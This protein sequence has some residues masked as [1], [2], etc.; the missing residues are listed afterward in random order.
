[1]KKLLVCLLSLTILI[2]L[3][4]CG[5]N[6][7][8]DS[9]TTTQAT[10]AK[11]AKEFELS[12]FDFVKGITAGWNLGNTLESHYEWGN[13]PKK[14]PT[15][16][17]VETGWNNPKTTKEMIDKVKSSGF[18][19]I[20][21]PVSWYIFTEEKNGNFTINQAWLNRVQEVVDYVVENDMYCIVN[22]H[23]DDRDW[24]Q[25][26]DNKDKFEKIK[27]RYKQVWKI[28]GT[29]FKD[30]GEKLVLEAANELLYKTQSGYDWW[31]QDVEYFA[32]QNELYKI[33]VDTVRA[34][35]GNNDKRYLMLPTYGAQWYAHQMSKLEIPNEDTRIIV[36]IHWYSNETNKDSIAWN[37]KE[38]YN[39]L[40][41]YNVPIII[42]ECG[43]KNEVDNGQKVAW[44]KVFVESASEYGIKCFIWD[45]GGNFQQLNRET[46]EWNSDSFI[47]SLINIATKEYPPLEL[48]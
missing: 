29:H 25:L 42:G 3:V 24:L 7:K 10:T 9:T 43:V 8:T 5:Q 28:I 1:M 44:T 6:P 12:A 32:R 4:S 34:T 13:I 14:N 31:G 40:L 46:L 45:D 37:F 19:A 36:D 15:P 17:Q 30:Y 35:G 27:N 2:S 16:E 33:F 41:Y 11:K 48:D 21:I 26:E 47:D 23:H 20:R 18:N 39:E 22:M 38:M